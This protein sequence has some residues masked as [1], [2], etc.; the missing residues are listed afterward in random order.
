VPPPI[1]DERRRL[2]DEQTAAALSAE[3]VAHLN[4][5]ADDSHQQV[6]VT[7]VGTFALDQQHA[8]LRLGSELD[9]DAIRSL[10]S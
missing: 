2:E 6:V 7:H 9:L 1:A 10:T 3:V 4:F 5:A 8:V